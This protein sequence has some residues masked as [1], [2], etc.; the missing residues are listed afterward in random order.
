MQKETERKKEEN[1]RK[2]KEK[3]MAKKKE[4]H[5]RASR[6]ADLKRRRR[7]EKRKMEEARKVLETEDFWQELGEQKINYSDLFKLNIFF[8]IS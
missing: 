4:G 1:Y 7:E 5:L 8:N 2:E 3:W 6:F